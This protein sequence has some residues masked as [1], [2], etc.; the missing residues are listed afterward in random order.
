MRKKIVRIG[1]SAGVTVSPGE[2]AALGLAVG[3]QVEVTVRA[4]VLEVVP[5]DKYVGRPL[6]EL[7]RLVDERLGVA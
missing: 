5:A 2:L 6:V 4:G 1:S 7:R 3:D